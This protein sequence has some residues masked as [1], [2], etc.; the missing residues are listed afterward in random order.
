V[1]R[2]AGDSSDYAFRL[3][4]VI[5]DVVMPTDY[6][7]SFP[8]VT[9]IIGEI[10][11]KPPSAMAWWGYRIGLSA[12]HEALLDDPGAIID[13]ETPE[14]LEAALKERGVSPN[15]KR[16]AAGERGTAAHD[17]LEA[18]ALGE[19]RQEI[20]Q[21]ATAESEM[22]ET[23]YGHAVISWW[24]EQIQPAHEAGAIDII[25]SERPVWSERHRYA[26][27]L[28]LALG[29]NIPEA[30]W[31]VIDAK[32]HKPASGFTKAGRGPAYIADLAQIRAYRMAW[33]EL[34]LG[35]TISQRVV[36]FR[37]NGKYLEDTREVPE[38]FFLLLRRLYDMKQEF[39]QGGVEVE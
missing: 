21:A 2:I 34:G 15:M 10:L 20:W 24:D 33:E 9:H 12:I 8:S 26:G 35:Q 39:D 7:F 22:Y 14:L 31:E 13:A 29:W 36:V 4:K 32:T 23:Q 18:L 5:G 19:D 28:D 17:I 30:G 38:D 3:C 6:G 16:D 1:T 27:T 11:A 37:P 25:E